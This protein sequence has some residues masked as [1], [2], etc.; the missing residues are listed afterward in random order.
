MSRLAAAIGVRSLQLKIFLGLKVV[1][2]HHFLPFELCLAAVKTVA[3]LSR[4]HLLTFLVVV[5]PSV[6]AKE[7]P[8]VV[9]VI[10]VFCN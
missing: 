10:F 8:G 2:G 4:R 3:L 7:A 6:T 9:F 5:R 1:F